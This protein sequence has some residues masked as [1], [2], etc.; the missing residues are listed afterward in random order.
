MNMQRKHNQDKSLLLHFATEKFPSSTKSCRLLDKFAEQEALGKEGNQKHVA[1]EKVPLLEKEFVNL[2]KKN[3][4][5]SFYTNSDKAYEY[6]L[7]L[8]EKLSY[9][10]DDVSLFALKIAAYQEKVYFSDNAGIFIS[11]LINKCEEKDFFL[12]L[13]HFSKPVHRIGYLNT[14]N[15]IVNGR[16]CQLE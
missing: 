9:S 3:Y 15:I 7:Y 16:F 5:F 6:S 2:M 1:N 12:N 14:K 11:A 8:I 10:A 4:N 13:S